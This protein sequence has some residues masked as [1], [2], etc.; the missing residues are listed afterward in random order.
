MPELLTIGEA[1][2]YLK[3]PVKTLR[4]WRLEGYGPPSM[5]LGRHVR[6]DKADLDAW[7]DEQKHRNGDA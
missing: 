1:S 7:I 2:S 6:Y 4:K 5:K 3:I